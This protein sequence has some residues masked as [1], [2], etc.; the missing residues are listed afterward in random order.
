MTAITILGLALAILLMI[1]VLYRMV[2]RVFLRDEPIELDLTQDELARIDALAERRALLV[3][4]LKDIEFDHETGKIDAQDYARLTR[5]YQRQWLEVD[6]ELES[7]AGLDTA[8]LDSVDAE[9]ERRL[10]GS[11]PTEAAPAR[12]QR[13]DRRICTA[14]GAASPREA[15]RC[16]DCEAPLGDC[17]DEAPGVSAAGRRT[18]ATVVSMVFAMALAV[19]AVALSPG[20]AAAQGAIAPGQAAPRDAIHGAPA[21]NRQAVV[22]LQPGDIAGMARARVA[23]VRLSQA[24]PDA[25]ATPIAAGTKVLLQ[26]RADRG[27][28]LALSYEAVTDAQGVAEFDSI[29]V[30]RDLRRFELRAI[31][32]EGGVAQ[33]SEPF[34]PQGERIDGTLRL[35][36]VTRDPD[37]VIGGSLVTIMGIP[38]RMNEHPASYGYVQVQ[39][40]VELGMRDFSIFDGSA[41]GVLYEVPIKAQSV[42]AQVVGGEG[43]TEVSDNKV[44]FNGTVYPADE[45]YPSTRL[46]VSYFLEANGSTLSFE[47]PMSLPFADIRATFLRETDL[48]GRE[49]LEVAFRDSQFAEF[50]DAAE[51]GTMEGRHVVVARGL[52][53]NKGEVLRFEVV[54]LPYPDDRLPWI[55]LGIAVLMVIGGVFLGRHEL[56]RARAR[57]AELASGGTA[58]QELVEAQIESLYAGL[59]ELERDHADGIIDVVDYERERSRLRTRLALLIKRRA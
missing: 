10:A 4:E 27:Q 46:M 12:A 30:L 36:P 47:Q 37:A 21:D 2:D 25:P 32:Q 48:P 17:R 20:T 3:R 34:L 8:L 9:L 39:Q 11:E 33:F 7:L 26:W 5:K 29:E 19:G 24:S 35:L 54:G 43:R 53:L 40:V 49:L 41:A 22:R 23:V 52:A 57:R 28:R 31:V 13:R 55:L 6:R 45:R 44:R 18:A 16:F 1:A 14:C 59:E 50:A 38:G 42:Q 56:Q 58:S 15:S 51:S